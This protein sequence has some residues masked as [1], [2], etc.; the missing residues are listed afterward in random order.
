MP[1]RAPTGQLPRSVQVILERDLVDKVKP[2]DRVEVSG[3]YR[4][5]PQSGITSGVFKQVLVATGIKSINAEK[6]RPQL[7]ETDIK[8]IRKISKEKNVFDTLSSAVAPSIQG[9]KNVKK[10]ILL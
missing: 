7:S 1:E 6:E 10:A 4:C 2:G 3:V 5:I 9:H 8:A